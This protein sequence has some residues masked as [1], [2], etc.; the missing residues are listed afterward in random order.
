MIELKYHNSVTD[1]IIWIGG[2]QWKQS[3]VY[4]Q[5]PI[6]SKEIIKAMHAL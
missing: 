1:P 6:S 4:I 5:C 3:K 2:V